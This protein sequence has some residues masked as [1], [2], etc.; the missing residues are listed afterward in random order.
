MWCALLVNANWVGHSGMTSAQFS[1]IT[2]SGL[3][4]LSGIFISFGAHSAL[5][6]LDT[7][8]RVILDWFQLKSYNRMISTQNKNNSNEFTILFFLISIF[9]CVFVFKGGQSSYCP[10]QN[11]PC[12][13]LKVILHFPGSRTELQT[14]DMMWSISW[15]LMILTMTN[16]L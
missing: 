15:T 10:R 9:V 7:T 1:L 2:S 6:N 5:P 11:F 3:W 16:Q 12:P 8:S 4:L 13:S 14:G